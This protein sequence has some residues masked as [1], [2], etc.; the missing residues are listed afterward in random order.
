MVDISD[1]T[2]RVRGRVEVRSG[3]IRRRRWTAEEKGRIVAVAVAPGAVI[4]D[5][6]R[7]HDLT[8]QHLSNWIR[9]AKDGRFAL[10]ADESVTFVP[11]VTSGPIAVAPSASS[12]ERAMLIEIGVGSIVVR[13][14]NGADGATL[15][16]VVRA[17]MRAAD[18]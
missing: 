11:L 13:V 16:A 18:R 2:Q 9:A 6:A 10:P 3:A 17:I 15:E 7:R 4:A 14:A 8:P 5:V 12:R 1:D